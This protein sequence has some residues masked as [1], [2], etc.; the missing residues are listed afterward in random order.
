MDQIYRSRPLRDYGW[1]SIHG[2]LTTM[3]GASAPGLGGGGHCD[4]LERER[5]GHRGFSAMTPF[6]GGAT[7]MAT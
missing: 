7:E 5:E 3:G 6:E 2:G 1:L 4:S